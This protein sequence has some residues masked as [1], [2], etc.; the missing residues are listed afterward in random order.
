MRQC[1]LLCILF[2]SSDNLLSQNSADFVIEELVVESKALN[3]DRRIS[4]YKPA[5]VSGPLS[6]IYLLD[7]EWNFEVTKGI[8][9]LFIRWSRIPSN[10]ALISVHN[11]GKRTL[12]MTPI[13]DDQRF[14]GSGGADAF[15]KFFS[16]ELIPFVEMEIGASSD[17]LIIGHSFGGLFA[18]Y[19]IGE[20]PDL[21]DGAIT[22]SPSTWYGNNYLTSTSAKEKVKALNESTYVLISS[23]EF[24][25]GNV[26]SNKAYYDWLKA[27]NPGLD[28]HY[29]KYDGRNHF[30]NVLTST[31]EGLTN[32]YPGPEQG[33]I[34]FST[35][36]RGG[37]E[38]LQAWYD[39]Q[40]NKYGARYIPPS[41]SIL[42]L[43]NQL[44]SKGEVEQA[45]KL[46]NW[47]ETKD[48][49]NGNLY[50]YLGALNLKLGKKEEARSFYS[51]ALTKKLPE[52]TKIVIKRNLD[53]I[54]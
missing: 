36:E 21:F 23:G 40:N 7:G 49:E 53:K 4:V 50:Y 51:T 25:R 9:D 29:A 33:P 30:T 1:F 8:L 3:E 24:D 15:L 47:F 19:A 20:Q 32:Y 46:L 14:P 34:I 17:R 13:E 6:T 42:T 38:E 11:Q 37:L 28:L 5:T 41:E 2:W 12:D 22:I 54:N 16:T 39:L 10:V 43:A 35:F 52:R 26:A 48:S 45:I 27:S 18:L 44:N 31:D